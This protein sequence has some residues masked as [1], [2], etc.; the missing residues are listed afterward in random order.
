MA[1]LFAQPAFHSHEYEDAIRLLLSDVCIKSEEHGY[2]IPEEVCR[3]PFIPSYVSYR[4]YSLEQL[5]TGEG[6]IHVTSERPQMLSFRDLG[7]KQSDILCVC[8]A[9]FP[10]D[11]RNFLEKR[12][13]QRLRPKE[14]S[15]IVDAD[16][17]ELI[18]ITRK[19]ERL[20]AGERHWISGVFQGLA[21][22]F[23][24]CSDIAV[25]YFRTYDGRTDT[26]T[27]TMF[28]K[29]S[30]RVY[31]NYYHPHIRNLIG[32]ILGEDDTYRDVAAHFLMREVLFSPDLKYTIPMREQL[33]AND[34]RSRFGEQAGIGLLFDQDDDVDGMRDLLEEMERLFRGNEI[35]KV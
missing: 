7:E 26:G 31:L 6:D 29:G 11:F 2:T 23:Q 5:D 4:P 25:G 17:I 1:R 9:D 14:S 10:W 28:H 16:N 12:Y 3:V 35:F 27:P 33:L 8:T 15:L 32:L 18:D 22:S 21:G 30:E 13:K 19:L 24:E 20:L 34:I